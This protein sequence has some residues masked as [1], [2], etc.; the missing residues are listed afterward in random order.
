MAVD[1]TK[2]VKYTVKKDDTL[3]EIA[4]DNFS[5]YGKKLGYSNYKDYMNKF[6]AKQNDIENV[7]FIYAGEKFIIYSPNNKTVKTTSSTT[8]SSNKATVNR[9][10]IV[11]N[12]DDKTLFATWKWD[13]DN[14]DRYKTRWRYDTGDGV[15][16][17]GKDSDSTTANAKYDTFD[18]PS[19]AISVTFYVK[20]VSKKH[21][22]NNKDTSYWT[23][24]WSNAKVHKV[25]VAPSQPSAPSIKMEGRELTCSVENITDA[26]HVE[27]EF[28]R[29]NK[30][31][32]VSEKIKIVTTSASI[33]RTMAAGYEYKVRCRTYK[34]S[35]ASEWSP[36]SAN[37]TTIPANVKSI[38]S[39][40]AKSETSVYLTWSKVSTATEYEIQHATDKDYF[41]KSNGVTTTPVLPDSGTTAPPNSYLIEGLDTGDEH[42]F[43]VRAKNDK[44]E[45]DWTAIKSVKLGTAPSAPTTWSETTT[46][47]SGKPVTLYFVHNTEDGSSMTQAQIQ[48]SVNDYTSDFEYSVEDPDDEQVDRIHSKTI[49]TGIGGLL[50]DGANCKWRVRTKG[51]IDKWSPWSTRRTIKIYAEPTV[52]LYI[53]GMP[54]NGDGITTITTFPIYISAET[55]PMANQKVIGYHLSVVSNSEYETEDELGNFKM[56]KKGDAMFSRQYDNPSTLENSVSINPKN[57]DLTNGKTYTAK[58]VAVMNSGL[59][60]TATHKFKVSWSEQDFEPDAEIGFDGADLSAIIQ[61]YCEYYKKRYYR[62]VYYEDTGEYK[63]AKT[64]WSSRKGTPVEDAYAEFREN[65][66]ITEEDVRGQFDEG[67]YQVYKGTDGVDDEYKYY[68]ELLFSK[69]TLVPDVTLSV[70][71]REF[72]GTFTE[73]AT[74]LANKRS[75]YVVDPH[76]SLDYARYRIVATSKTT[77]AVGFWDLPSYP[78][79]WTSIVI[80]WDEEW[81]QFDVDDGNAQEDMGYTGSILELPYDISVSDSNSPDVELVEYIGRE[82]PVSYYG[83]QQGYSSTWTTNIPKDDKETLY[84]LRRLQRWMGD[85]YVREP[86]GSGYWAN[87][88]VQFSQKSRDLVIPVTFNIKKVE[89][90][91]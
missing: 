41:G 19:N 56:V 5:T 76:P 23:A 37:E 51:I 57:I 45:S 67:F 69:K 27:F 15:S 46:V 74:N 65:S 9:F 75:T 68:T 1:Y 7:N 21:K 43:R 20:P 24:D 55:S 53:D 22:V 3:S 58:V 28:A 8:T 2:V 47:I 87:I 6:I 88:N 17:I 52:D 42:F 54:D 4:Y 66:S 13:K 59:T 71:R 78:I 86:S 30:K 38:T 91:A 16:F 10:G 14:T 39:I 12:T 82:N 29:D 90:G 79:G 48:I 18:I 89:G 32:S 61:P 77:G 84:A 44:G 83:T 11:N 64:W 35:V 31:T 25:V 62:V 70:Y 34:G 50:T 36:Y 33:T 49:N 60:A 63:I 72:D 81:S 85:V 26:T 80:Q 73:I 40:K